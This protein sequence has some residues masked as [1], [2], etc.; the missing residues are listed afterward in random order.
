MRPA[1]RRPRAGLAC[2]LF[3]LAVACERA[4][5]PA[6]G[7]SARTD[8]LATGADSVAAPPVRS[9][10]EA[11]YGVVLLVAEDST[12]EASVVFPQLMDDAQV[13]P[14]LDTAVTSRV[15]FELFAPGGRVGSGTLAEP[16][17]LGEATP[18]SNEAGCWYWPTVPLKGSTAP[19]GAPPRW[20]VG[21]A[22]GIATPIPL[23]SIEALTGADSAALAAAAVRMA[24]TLPGDTAPSFRGLPFT[25]RTVRRFRLA[26]DREGLVA[27]L[28]RTINQEARAA[29]QHTFVVAERP[30]GDARAKWT[31]V[32][33]ER[34]EGTDE[35]VATTEVLAA[36][37]IVPTDRTTF[38][39]RRD[40]YEG[41]RFALLERSRTGEWK[42]RWTSA[43]AGC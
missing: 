15:P 8:S 31:P 24:S 29:E 11:A 32:Y 21:F 28:V 43:Y 42:V 12:H 14:T 37:H 26:P 10:W 13:D 38:V 27:E 18:D 35:T 33:F 3:A 9:G 39:L 25:A 5:P 7:D 34:T 1:L 23:D 16:I 36:V 6:A 41:S 22:R 30:L 4:S 40:Y 17:T 20:S 19:D 2:A